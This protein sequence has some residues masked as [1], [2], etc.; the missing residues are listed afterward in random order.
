MN[1]VI[2]TGRR[3][4]VYGLEQAAKYTRNASKVKSSVNSRYPIVNA[5]E[6]IKN[7][8]SNAACYLDVACYDEAF[9]NTV[10]KYTNDD[11]IQLAG[12][13]RPINAYGR[14][15]NPLESFKTLL[16]ER[17]QYQHP[18]KNNFSSK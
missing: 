4:V 13:L 18:E 15:S 5:K 3:E 1:N 11:F 2:F 8:E 9:C 14:T 7:A 10:T 12:N 6:Y 16:L 17:F